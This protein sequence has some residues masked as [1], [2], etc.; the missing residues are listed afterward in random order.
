MTNTKATA[1]GVRKAGGIKSGGDPADMYHL[2]KLNL[3]K[4]LQHSNNIV[5]VVE[6]RRQNRFRIIHYLA[7]KRTVYSSGVK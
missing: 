2:E 7:E 4:K 5:T 6:T 3:R 1:T